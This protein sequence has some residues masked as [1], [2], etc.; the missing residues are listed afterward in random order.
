MHVLRAAARSPVES[1]GACFAWPPARDFGI[2][3]IARRRKSLGHVRYSRGC[4]R[5]RAA[6]TSGPLLV[7][8][9]HHP[10]QDLSS[11]SSRSGLPRFVVLRGVRGAFRAGCLLLSFFRVH[12]ADKRR[13]LDHLALTRQGSKLSRRLLCG[14]ELALEAAAGGC[15][16]C[17]LG[18]ASISGFVVLRCA[19]SGRAGGAGSDLEPRAFGQ[20]ALLGRPACACVQ[21][22]HQVVLS[23]QCSL[24][25]LALCGG[26]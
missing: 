8:S 18:E 4:S 26:R 2:G 5:E 6:Q 16:H 23:L 20:P 13:P 3:S 25:R 19:P 14:R 7:P 17:A 12:Q 11:E 22:S 15:M 10:D 1:R 24:A 9:G 21:P